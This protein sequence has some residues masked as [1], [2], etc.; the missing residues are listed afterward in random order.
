MLKE[1]L[2][3]TQSPDEPRRRCF[4][5]TESDLYVWYD[6]SGQVIQFQLCYDKGPAEKAFTWSLAQ[7]VVHHGVD[8]GSRSGS[9]SA[10]GTPILTARQPLDMAPL[11]TLFREHGR[12]LEHDLYEFVLQ[13]LVESAPGRA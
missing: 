6:D 8:D 12:K 10:K 5:D 7:G 2:N 11:V 3:A 4:T 13:R 1:T 9:F